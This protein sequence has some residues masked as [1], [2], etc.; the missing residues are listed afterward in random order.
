MCKKESFAIAHP[1][2]VKNR[3]SELS[4]RSDDVKSRLALTLKALW[5]PERELA[6]LSN[7]D[8]FQELK[9]RFPHFIEVVELLESNA[10]ALSKLDLPFECPP[11]LLQ[12][13]PG[14]GK[15]YFF[16]EL[17][18]LIEFPFYEIS[19]AT[20]TASFALAGG[21]TQWSEGT[22]GFIAKS[23]ASSRIANPIILIDEIDKCRGS[24]HYDPVNVLYSLLEP[25][26]AKRFRDEALEIELDTSRIIW[27]ATA[28]YVDSIP[29]PILS[30]MRVISIQLPTPLQMINIVESIYSS[31]RLTKSY[32]ALMSPIIDGDTMQLLTTKS[33]REARVAIDIGCL[34]AIRDNRSHLRP[35]DIVLTK[36]E[37][38]HAGFY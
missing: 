20:I 4:K 7:T 12:G 22:V 24:N 1:E 38:L 28:N 26:S 6:K 21:S 29:E 13:D 3:V 30:R 16:S 23:L 36:K 19:M 18:R 11:L 15:T 2:Q 27:I 32:G 34:S 35:S 14:L 5:Q 37:R 17:A 8:I 31:F 33:P 25:H 10:I 9:D